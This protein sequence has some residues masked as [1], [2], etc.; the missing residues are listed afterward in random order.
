MALTMTSRPASA[1]DRLQRRCEDLVAAEVARL[2]RRLPD[3]Q[4]GTRLA[5]F[6]LA[7]SR[8]VDQLVLSRVHAVADDQIA[9]LFDLAEARQ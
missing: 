3:G 5:E 2:A 7:L 9:A 6:E 4:R 1:G 8:L